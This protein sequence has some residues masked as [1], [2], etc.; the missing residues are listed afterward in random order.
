MRGDA[1]SRGRSRRCGFA[2]PLMGLAA[3]ALIPAMWAQGHLDTARAVAISDPADVSDIGVEVDAILGLLA[4][5]D[6]RR[7]DAERE[8][9][10]QTR[11]S[12]CMYES[13]FE[14]V[15]VPLEFNDVRIWRSGDI[16]Y[17]SSMGF[18]IYTTILPEQA[19]RVTEPRVN[20]ND[21]Y[22]DGL[23]PTAA[24]AYQRVLD[25]CWSVRRPDVDMRLHPAISLVLTDFFATVDS[26]QEMVEARAAWA[27]CMTSTGHPYASLDELAADWFD[28]E[29]WAELGE[30]YEEQAWDPSSPAH[31]RWSALVTEERSVATAA[32]VCTADLEATR[33]TVFASRRE[34]LVETIIAVDW[35]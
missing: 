28:A 12:E 4:P 31:E 3:V 23:S 19:E 6:L 34:E 10:Y 1:A 24:D 5:E 8:L 20:P 21:A 25:N 15:P 17:A 30:F 27:E 16:E 26:S 11:I 32:A 33:A 18:G 14:Y 9:A 35:E 29:R 13:G 7:F 22:V 2:R